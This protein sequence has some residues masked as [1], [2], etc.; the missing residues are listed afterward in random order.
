MT[1]ATTNTFPHNFGVYVHAIHLSTYLGVKFLW[2]KFIF[3]IPISSI[4]TFQLLHIFI[5]FVTVSLFSFLYSSGYWYLLRSEFAFPWWLM[6]LSMF[7]YIFLAIGYVLFE[8]CQVS[9]HI[10]IELSVFFLLTCRNLCKD[11]IDLVLCTINIFSHCSN[12]AL[13]LG[14]WL[15]TGADFSVPML[16]RCHIDSTYPFILFCV[17]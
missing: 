14:W 3:N 12:V 17:S 5:T 7:S 2:P 11:W 13:S 1:N 9:S 8:V 4:W 6:R 16:G 10:P 15:H